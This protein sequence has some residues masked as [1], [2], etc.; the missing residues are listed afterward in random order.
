MFLARELLQVDLR[1][2]QVGMIQEHLDLADIPA[3]LLEEIGPRRRREWAALYPLRVAQ[4]TVKT[5]KRS[6]SR[7]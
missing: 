4:L 6:P 5:G 2:V 7:T 1:C 3:R